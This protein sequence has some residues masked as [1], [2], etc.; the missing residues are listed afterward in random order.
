MDS[1]DCS[2]VT[3]RKSRWGGILGKVFRIRKPKS[4]EKV[5]VDAGNNN[6]DLVKRSEDD[7]DDDDGDEKMAVEAFVAKVFA[8]LS[9]VKAAYAELQFAHS[10]YDPELIRAADQMVVSELKLLSELKRYFSKK[11]ID[12]DRDGDRGSSPGVTLLLAEI[13]EQNCVLRMYE[14]MAKKMDSQVKLKGSEIMFLKAKLE[15]ANKENKLLEKRLNS[16]SELQLPL[17]DN[18]RLST[19]NYSHFV[20]FF[21][22]TVSSIRSFVRQLCWEMESAGWDLDAAA[23]AIQP[24][25]A[26][27]FKVKN[28]RCFAF[29]SYVCRVMFDGFDRPNFSLSGEALQDPEKRQR[30]FAEVNAVKKAADYL[31]RK[32]KSTFARFCGKKYRR[33][34]HPAMEESLFG[35]D[36]DHRKMVKSGEFPATGFFSCFAEMAKR[37]WL[38]HCLAFSFNPEAS[39]FQVSKGARFSDV[40]MD[41]ANDEPVLSWDGSPE[42]QP[43]VAFTVVPGFRLGTTVIQCLVFLC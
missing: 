3:P 38:L 24:D 39:I 9:A 18:L 27:L 23:S 28:R 6:G 13:K 8:S 17:P 36:C 29:E 11:Q 25:S 15:E 19:L 20:R 26:A 37:V 21:R 16:T 10:P 12:R 4:N 2:A 34:V 41:N 33:L 32:P 7:D 1:V 5:K 35:G 30:R 14:S 22:Q 42:T 40:Y 31:A 43:K